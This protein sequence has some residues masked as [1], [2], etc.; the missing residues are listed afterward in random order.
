MDYSQYRLFL[1]DFR[2][3]TIVPA[4]WD[5]WQTSPCKC[6]PN[7]LLY[8][9]VSSPIPRVEA[10]LAHT[11]VAE[12]PR[13]CFWCKAYLKPTSEV[14]YWIISHLWSFDQKQKTL[15]YCYWEYMTSSESICKY[16]C[17]YSIALSNL[18]QCNR[19]VLKLDMFHSIHMLN[20]ST[21]ILL[22]YDVCWYIV[23]YE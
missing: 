2:Q 19:G 1:K 15:P 6:A 11:W 7:C 3:F 21:S 22:M 23:E 17:L 16:I 10:T 18:F 12:G 8:P 5:S 13:E 20:K 14:W 4:P 9:L